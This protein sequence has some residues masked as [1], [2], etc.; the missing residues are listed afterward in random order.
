MLQLSHQENFSFN[1][2]QTKDETREVTEGRVSVPYFRFREWTGMF[3]EWWTK[4]RCGASETW[5]TKDMGRVGRVCRCPQR[6]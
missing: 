3:L 6:R 4:N 2:G 5:K 1:L